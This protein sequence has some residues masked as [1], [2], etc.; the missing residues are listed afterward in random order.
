MGAASD[1]LNVLKKVPGLDLALELGKTWWARHPYRQAAQ[2]VADVAKAA[3]L[4][5]A[6]RHPLALVAG[7]FVVGGVLAWSRPWRWLP[8]SAL[9]A[10]LLAKVMAQQP[11]CQSSV[12]V[13]PSTTEQS[14]R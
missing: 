1:W 10:A 11:A 9:I 6:Q 7:A 4:P 8:T 2:T 13:A 5:T 3:V 14:G 12:K